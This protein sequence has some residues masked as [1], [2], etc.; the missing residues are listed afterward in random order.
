MGNLITDSDI[1]RI[2]AEFPD[3]ITRRL[4]V[5]EEK[6]ALSVCRGLT[7][8]QACR[9]VGVSFAEAKELQAD[10][11]FQICCEYLKEVKRGYQDVQ[12]VI[13]R[14]MLNGMLLEAHRKAANTSEEVMAIREMGKMNDLYLDAQR[15]N[16]TE[17][18]DMKDITSAKQ[19]ERL[20]DAE[21][22][23]LSGSDFRLETEPVVNPEVADAG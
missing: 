2:Q 5:I 17:P 4:S 9:S 22:I 11:F 15:R 13:T 14:D 21:L 18:A 20:D 3:L 1:D 10:S 8:P 16:G 12:A 7:I 6:I 19:L 23:E